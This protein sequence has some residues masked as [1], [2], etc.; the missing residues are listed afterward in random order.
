MVISEKYC[1]TMWTFAN[2]WSLILGN[3][4]I[5]SLNSTTCGCIVTFLGGLNIIIILAFLSNY[6][7]DCFLYFWQD[8]ISFPGTVPNCSELSSLNLLEHRLSK[9]HFNNCY[10]Y[11]AEKTEGAVRLLGLFL[12]FVCFC[13]L[14]VWG[15][16]FGFFFFLP[17][18]QMKMG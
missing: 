9:W 17:K 12:F 4:S 16:Y 18:I 7:F 6:C 11:M 13:F 1:Q 8:V 5:F 14:I 15:F 3:Y 10:K 2:Q